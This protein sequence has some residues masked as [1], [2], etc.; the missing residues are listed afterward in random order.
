MQ[1]QPLELSKPRDV[2]LEAVGWMDS[3]TGSQRS[4]PT[5][6]FH[7]PLCPWEPGLG[8]AR[9]EFTSFKIPPQFGK[10]DPLELEFALLGLPWAEFVP[11]VVSK[12]RFLGFL[13]HILFP[14]H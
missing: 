14:I 4:F 7:D 12:E 9:T 6:K 13:D 2:A 5:Q 11:K 1:P 3:Q 10:F 8:L